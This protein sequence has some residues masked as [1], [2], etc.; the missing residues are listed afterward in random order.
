MQ[1]VSALRAMAAALILAACSSGYIVAADS[2]TGTNSS[3]INNFLL[4][5][6]ENTPEISALWNKWN[7]KQTGQ[8]N[9]L[10]VE[11][12]QPR[13]RHSAQK[14]DSSSDSSPQKTNAPNSGEKTAVPPSQQSGKSDKQ[15]Q[16]KTSTRRH[17][18]PKQNNTSSSGQPVVA[19]APATQNGYY[20][21]YSA[22]APA[23]QNGYYGSYSAV[24]PAPQ[25][26]YYGGY[27]A[28]A[29]APQPSC[30]RTNVPSYT[31]AVTQGSISSSSGS[32]SVPDGYQVIP[33]SSFDLQ[34]SF[35]PVAVSRLRKTDDYSDFFSVVFP[36]AAITGSG[37]ADELFDR[38]DHVWKEYFDDPIYSENEGILFA[39]DMFAQGTHVRILFP[40]P[41][42][43]SCYPVI[44]Q[45][46]EAL[47]FC[48]KEPLSRSTHD[49][50]LK[51]IA[52]PNA[53]V[54]LCK[55]LCDCY[56]MEANDGVPYLHNPRNTLIFMSEAQ[57][58]NSNGRI[59]AIAY[60][61]RVPCLDIFSKLA[62]D[63]GIKPAS[64]S[65]YD[66]FLPV[67]VLKS[68]ALAIKDDS[69]LSQD[70]THVFPLALS[71]FELL[72]CESVF[73]WNK[74]ITACYS[75]LLR[76]DVFRTVEWK[77]PELAPFLREEPAERPGLRELADFLART[78]PCEQKLS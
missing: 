28:V 5:L 47:D 62:E 72:S 67:E 24:A 37:T 17:S 77:C 8:D 18:A 35:G 76:G 15:E 45:F 52:D 61:R 13:R 43:S 21:S 38:Y 71:I 55:Q 6:N 75:A 44:L 19:V 51:F 65:P 7:R 59:Y 3:S 32:V 26:G 4:F 22:V 60:V 27:S 53:R 68:K 9:K 2:A 30:Y 78:H 12:K 73:G 16:R 36:V 63:A 1:Y 69:H 42:V 39:S 46:S 49:Y 56:L 23:P 57:E 29:P 11:K 40:M 41:P 34:L 58:P 70:K 14:Q 33:G 64:D 54:G 10:L 31:A 48:K 20:G 50:A 66:A 74:D 25:N